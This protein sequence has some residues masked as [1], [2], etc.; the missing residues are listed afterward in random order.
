MGSSKG[1][2]VLGFGIILT[3]VIAMALDDIQTWS[4]GCLL[5]SFIFMG[6]AY[7][8]Y[9][10][11][12]FH[13]LSLKWELFLAFMAPVIYPLMAIYFLPRDIHSWYVSRSTVRGVFEKFHSE[14]TVWSKFQRDNPI[15]D[16][17]TAEV[18]KFFESYPHIF[19]GLP[20]GIACVDDYT[21]HCNISLRL[22]SCSAQR[23]Y[24]EW[25]RMD[26]F[27]K[28]IAEF[29]TRKNAS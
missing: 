17:R 2:Y 13:K 4:T 15:A 8:D 12:N 19:E 6:R 3:L 28:A 24:I 1:M 7:R 10:Q 21:T 27:Q 9:Q 20:G 25:S 23:Y 14:L 22:G 18:A 5:I 16:V 29:N 11:A 26:E